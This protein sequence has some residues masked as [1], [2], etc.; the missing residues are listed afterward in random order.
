MKLICLLHKKPGRAIK[1]ILLVSKKDLSEELKR[2]R[3]LELKDISSYYSNRAVIYY[4]N[5]YELRN[6]A[7]AFTLLP[8]LLY[9]FNYTANCKS[10]TLKNAKE[11]LFSLISTYP[12]I[13]GRESE[14][15][16]EKMVKKYKIKE[17]LIEELED[18]KIVYSDNEKKLTLTI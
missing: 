15:I 11:F 18:L 12:Y 9:S 6:L 17:V 3:K 13:N 7:L 4:S 14:E 2:K 8:K 10:S 5:K 1:I 16:L